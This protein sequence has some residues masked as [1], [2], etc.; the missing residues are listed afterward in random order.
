MALRG[1]KKPSQRQPSSQT[2][3]MSGT[4]A[5]LGFLM[6]R[7]TLVLNSKWEEHQVFMHVY[8][9]DCRANLHETTDA[10]HNWKIPFAVC[11][12]CAMGS[13]SASRVLTCSGKAICLLRHVLSGHLWMLCSLVADGQDLLHSRHRCGR[14]WGRGPLAARTSQQ[15]LSKSIHVRLSSQQRERM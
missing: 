8:S 2:W 4:I 12:P 7:L 1:R 13:I 5:G 9:S 14:R 11:S 6:Q 10:K 15:E 3:S